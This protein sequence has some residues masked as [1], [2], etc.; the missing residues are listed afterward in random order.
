MSHFVGLDASKATTSICVIDR[1]G[2]C[3]REG[4]VETEPRAI[5][6]FLRGE[7]RRY[8]RVGIESMSFTPWLYEPLAKAGLPVICIEAS[9]ARSLLK[10]RRNKTD[11]N[12]ARGIAEI[13]RAG[14][15]KA[16]HIK[17][18][19]SQEAKLVLTARS[20][21]RRKGRDI[22]NL[23]RAI[24]LQFGHKVS[25]GHTKDFEKKASTVAPR[26][27]LLRQITDVMLAVHRFIDQQ[28]A[29]LEETIAGIVAAD[30][31]CQRFMTTPGVGPLTALAVRAAID[32][33]E[34][35]VHSRDV[36]VH[37]GL[38]P[39]AFR[40]GTIDRKGHISKFGDEE[41]RT[42]LFLAA[43]SLLAVRTRPTA[44]K[45]WGRSVVA[46]R[47]YLRGV[48]AVARKLAV[49]L[50]RMWL[51]GTDFRAELATTQAA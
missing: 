42:A 49:I 12:D 29:V 1:N 11:R 5:I 10:A 23:A 13:M 31:V 27:D 30:P 25:R 34:R 40:S 15:Y 44:L 37:L 20:H 38:T 8:R 7:G 43:K 33:P 36:G 22:D 17:T 26:G 14:V 3:V 2:E 18:K 4:V 35:F 6:R 46:S 24:L 50:H 9:H 45:A 19:A 41:A 39:R 16:V 21:L 48:I 32:V 51:D 47:G 28:I